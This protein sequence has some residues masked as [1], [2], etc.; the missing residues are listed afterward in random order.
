ME[1]LTDS[2]G[3]IQHAIFSIPNRRTGY[4]TDDNARALIAAVME[5]ERTGSRQ[6]LQL[7][8]K[9][10]S[11]LHY[12][13]T[14]SGHFHNFMSYDQVWLDDQGS[15]DCFGR[16]LWGCGY[17]L[18]AELHPNVKKVAKQMFD[19]AMRWVPLTHSLRARA[20]M[21]MGLYYYLKFDPDSTSVRSALEKAADSICK[22]YHTNA[23]PEWTWFEDVMTYSNG[24]I[25]RALFMAYQIF[26]KQEYLDVAVK[27]LDFLTSV[28]ILDGMLYPIGCNG[29]YMRDYE[30]AWYDQQPVDPMGHTLSYLSAYDATQDEKYLALA[31]VCFV[32]FFGHNSVGEAL[33]DPVTG[34][35][36]DA[37]APDGANL[38]Q[39]SESTV[40]CLLT[41][42]AMQPYLSKL[43]K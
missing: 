2:T 6:V 33:Y 40:C 27:S 41:Q 31:K 10:L 39:G 20:Y 43:P 4:T 22:E 37:L 1:T 18:S 38:N 28:C 26:G 21:S 42:L 17:A 19:G 24:M 11:F 12:A 7:V 13:Q 15:E 5:F 8:S 36:F 3:V 32:W 25:P 14:P 34:G 30:R 23:E 35:C 29:W 9:Y 16:T